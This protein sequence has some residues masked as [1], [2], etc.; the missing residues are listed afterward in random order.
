MLT[1][2]I[3][4]AVGIAAAGILSAPIAAAE[5]TNAEVASSSA[6][7]VP[8]NNITCRPWYHNPGGYK[9]GL[10]ASSQAMLDRIN[11]TR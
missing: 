7:P 10:N 1:K 2:L 5:P 11:A 4:A 9:N 8:C 3:I 6:L